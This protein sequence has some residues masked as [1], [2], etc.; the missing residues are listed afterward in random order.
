MTRL[1]WAEGFGLSLQ[2]ILPIATDLPNTYI[3]TGGPPVGQPERTNLPLRS[4]AESIQFSKVQLLLS[5]LA[6]SR[7]SFVTNPRL[8]IEANAKFHQLALSLLMGDVV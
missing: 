3:P 4:A 6:K 8:V 1:R 5:G 2:L 7:R